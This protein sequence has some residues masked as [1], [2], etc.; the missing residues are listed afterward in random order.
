MKHC[1]KCSLE[2]PDSF[3]FC[4][5]CGGPLTEFRSC[6]SCGELAE[7]KWTFCTSC[8]KPLS[9]DTT[10]AQVSPPKTPEPANLPASPSSSPAPRTP[11]PPTLT[12]PSS[13]Q[14]IHTDGQRTEKVTPQEWYSAADLYDDSTTTTPAP[15][16]RQQERVPKTTAPIPQVTIPPPAKDEKSA[17]ALTMLSAY[18]AS[19]APSQFRWWHG[20]ILALFV[21]LIIGG[22]GIGGWYWWSHRGSVAQIT[23]PA[24]SNNGPLP[25]SSATFP[26]PTST[27]TTTPSQTS[28]SNSADQE[29]KLL[30]QRRTG[31]KPSESAEIIAAFEGAEKKYPTDYRFPYERAKLSITGVASHHEAF[32]ALALAAEKAIDN[33]KAE[34]MLDSLLADKDGDFRKL[35]RGHHEWEALEDALRNK[36]RTG[37]KVLHH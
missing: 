26:S 1:P 14:S 7:G 22:I 20:A 34:E 27:L 25:E 5:S 11:A 28:T 17:P 9:P 10:S 18:G 33:G 8:G 35:S 19:E 2:F 13:E 31:A 12:L 30:R 32:G 23:P 3:R 4:G 16:I 24:N 21:L 36:D 6:P 29:I 37:L 15:P